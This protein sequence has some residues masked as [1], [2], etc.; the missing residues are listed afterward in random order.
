MELLQERVTLFSELA[1]A[2]GRSGVGEGAPE[3]GGTPS[4]SSD[5]RKLFRADSTH[6]PPA[7]PLLSGAIR[8]GAD[9]SRVS[10]DAV[11]RVKGLLC[12]FWYSVDKLSHLLAGCSIIKA[13]VANCNQE[14]SS[15]GPPS[16]IIGV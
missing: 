2:T 1:E 9:E 10:D 8:E 16:S 14:M 11:E 7:G 15:E 3:V 12:S 13:S 4:R 5:S 6:A